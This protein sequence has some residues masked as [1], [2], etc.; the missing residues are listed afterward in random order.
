MMLIDIYALTL[1]KTFDFELDE[2]V[3]VEELT[4]EILLLIGQKENLSM[5]S[6]KESYLYSVTRNCILRRDSDLEGQGM[7]S[8]E[9]LLLL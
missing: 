2:H 4:R 7:K 1:D 3:S 6:D 8:G 5:V 9:Q